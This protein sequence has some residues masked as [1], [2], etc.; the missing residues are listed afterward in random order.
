MLSLQP[1]TMSELV[2]TLSFRHDEIVNM[3]RFLVDEGYVTVKDGK[4]ILKQR[5]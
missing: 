3:V 4:Y 2:D 5:S 1:R